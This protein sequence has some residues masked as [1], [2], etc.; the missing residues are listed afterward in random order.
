MCGVDSVNRR[1]LAEELSVVRVVDFFLFD[2]NI[3]LDHSVQPVTTGRV[4][5]GD[6][7]RGV[8]MSDRVNQE[9]GR[10]GSE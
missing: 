4:D 9:A 2:R 8:F 1:R 6:S 10:D 7:R 5:L 3:I